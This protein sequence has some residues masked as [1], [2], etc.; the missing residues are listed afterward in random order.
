MPILLEMIHFDCVYFASTAGRGADALP[1]QVPVAN[2]LFRMNIINTKIQFTILGILWTVSVIVLSVTSYRKI[3]WHATPGTVVLVYM[4]AGG[5]EC[6]SSYCPAFG[7]E[8]TTP[9]FTFEMIDED[10]DD[11]VVVKYKSHHSAHVYQVGEKR[12]VL[13]HPRRNNPQPRACL[14]QD[15]LMWMTIAGGGVLLSSLLGLVAG[16]FWW[17]ETTLLSD[18]SQS[19]SYSLQEYVA[20]QIQ[21]SPVV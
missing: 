12:T 19:Q 6:S 9:V 7:D 2:N 18:E 14:E 13:Y 4:G 16:V 1:R 11:V 8:G 21:L 20:P 17:Y 10:D 3:F 5:Y 15:I